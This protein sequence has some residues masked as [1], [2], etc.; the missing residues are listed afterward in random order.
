MSTVDAAG[1]GTACLVV[2]GVSGSGK[3]TVAR[4]VADTLGWEFAEG[5]RLHPPE[6]IAKMRR[7]VPLTDAD[8]W[9][10]LDR[11]GDWLDVQAAKD[12]PGVVTCSALRRS[13]RDLLAADRPWVRFC[14]VDVPEEVLV[15]RLTGRED[16]F[17]PASLL[18]SQLATLEPLQAD[19]PGFVV[20]GTKP[21]QDV[22]DE[23]R[24]SL[25]L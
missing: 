12:E 17:M 16:H 6:N 23:V 18:A 1:N 8:R 10:W 7:G 22:V 3:T 24:R 21:V 11:V 15:R 9:P 19:E 25:E 20:D 13:Y 2:M 14:L 4:A 5:D